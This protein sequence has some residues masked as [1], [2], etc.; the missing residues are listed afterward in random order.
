MLLR[1]TIIW[2]LLAFLAVLNGTVREVFIT[3]AVGEQAG[4]ASSTVV[5]CIVIVAVA[6][7]S[8][9]WIGPSSRRDAL[10]VGI[11]WVLLAIAF[12]FM[13]GHYLFGNSWEMLLA[14]YNIL[15]GRIW[16]LV[17]FTSLL[18]PIWAYRIRRL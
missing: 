18:A 10:T 12:E 7:V 9:G 15:R 8:L 13:A 3:P 2:F 5:F 6:V 14:D 17:P 16:L 11:V 4:H 1:A